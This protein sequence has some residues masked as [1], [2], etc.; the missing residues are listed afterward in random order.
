MSP[1]FSYEAYRQYEMA[2]LMKHPQADPEIL[3]REE[4]KYTTDPKDANP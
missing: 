3:A 2:Q 4:Q 1:H